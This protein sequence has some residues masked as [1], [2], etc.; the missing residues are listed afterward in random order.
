M[1]ADGRLQLHM[2]PGTLPED[3]IMT[4]QRLD[5]EALPGQI[6]AIV[7]GEAVGY[8]IEPAG[9]TLHQPIYVTLDLS[10]AE[11][12]EQAGTGTPG[13][14]IVTTMPNGLIGPVGG[15]V[16][17]RQRGSDRIRVEFE[18]TEL[19]TLS[20]HTVG[21]QVG[22]SGDID[23]P[24]GVG[25]DIELRSWTEFNHTHGDDSNNRDGFTYT[26]LTATE[27]ISIE[28]LSL[29][30]SLFGA[31]PPTMQPGVRVRD[32]SGVLCT[33]PGVGTVSFRTI[34]LVDSRVSIGIIFDTPI[35]CVQN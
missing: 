12:G 24:Q 30:D 28:A 22:M 6:R 26:N 8:T 1:S 2:V 10:A 11:L 21:V 23:G 7:G 13:I 3:T 4:I 32:S 25:T 15:V 20:W 5:G 19:G 31:Q 33:Q 16:T 29:Y 34:A 27:P 35:E 18:V 9:L 17:S 14:A